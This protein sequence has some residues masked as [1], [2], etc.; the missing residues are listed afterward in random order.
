[1]KTQT[2]PLL[3]PV[4]AKSLNYIPINETPFELHV[5]WPSDTGCRSKLTFS[6]SVSPQELEAIMSQ[7]AISS[8]WLLKIFI[9]IFKE[10]LRAKL[11][12]PVVSLSL[13]TRLMTLLNMPEKTSITSGIPFE[14]K[15]YNKQIT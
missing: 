8:K 1:M 7:Y 14:E 11:Q 12:A 9:Q 4:I 6:E 10:Y 5:F 13:K 2:A 3:S 15:V